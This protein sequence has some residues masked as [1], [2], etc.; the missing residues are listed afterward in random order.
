MALHT[1]AGCTTRYAIG[2]EACPNCGSAERTRATPVM[3]T[4]EVTCR[5]TGCPAKDQ[6]RPVVLRQAAVGVLHIPDH[7]AC[8]QCGLAMQVTRPYIGPLFAGEQEED[9]MPKITRHGGASIAGEREHEGTGEPTTPVEIPPG[10]GQSP[11]I[12]GDGS[13]Q[14]LPDA[15]EQ[16]PKPRRRSKAKAEGRA[17]EMTITADAEVT[18][19]DGKPK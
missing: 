12:T 13:G 10:G 11:E 5:T 7:L 15:D 2:L 18:G 9:A 3:P 1:C 6:A 17:A 16:P 4:I 8:A 19:P 14:A